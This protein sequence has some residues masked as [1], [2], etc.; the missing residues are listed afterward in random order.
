MSEII[1]SVCIPAYRAEKYVAAAIESV[2]AQMPPSSEVIVVDDGSDDATA[3]V[4]E[5]FAPPV[6][7]VRRAHQGIGATFNE[8]VSLSSGRLLAAIDADDLWLP[9][10]MNAQLEEMDRDPSLDAVFG[11]SYEFVSPDLPAELQQRWR[12]NDVPSPVTH[13]GTM[14]LRREAWE[15]VGPLPEDVLLGE[16]VDWYARAVDAGLRMK[17]LDEVVLARRIHGGNTVLR[18]RDNRGDY[19]KVLKATLD[20]RRA[21]DDGRKND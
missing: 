21:A 4:A 11:H 20:R 17:M 13:R 1:L 12:C 5:R 16:F 8:A 10:K 15:R 18:E 14:L 7:V 3:V 2:L 19:L 9:G 6:R